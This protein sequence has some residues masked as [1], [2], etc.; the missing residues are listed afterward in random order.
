MQ[1]FGVRRV[2]DF[3]KAKWSTI[4]GRVRRTL[5]VTP[6]I[7][8]VPATSPSKHMAPDGLDLAQLRSWIRQGRKIVL[9]YRDEQ[10]RETDRTV[11]PVAVGYHD[12]V[13]LIAAWCELRRDFRHFRS[14]RVADA[15]FLDEHYPARPAILRAQWRQSVHA[16][17]QT[18]SID[19]EED[20]LRRPFG[21]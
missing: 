20:G 4:T 18:R 19:G 21:R 7:E 14:D 1:N 3:R 2:A 5:P 15:S 8:E 16:Q 9:S 11:W 10:G 13:R 12:A 6:S 17:D